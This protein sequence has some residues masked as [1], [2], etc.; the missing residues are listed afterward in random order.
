MQKYSIMQKY[1]RENNKNSMYLLQLC[2]LC[3]NYI[4]IAKPLKI[5]YILKCI[6]SNQFFVK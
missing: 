5:I 2:I 4:K 1:S 6:V 3:D